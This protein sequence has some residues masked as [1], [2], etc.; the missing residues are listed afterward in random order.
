[1]LSLSSVLIVK[2][3]E[4]YLIL[5]LLYIFSTLVLPVVLKLKSEGRKDSKL[6]P[7]LKRVKFFGRNVNLD[8]KNVVSFM[9]LKITKS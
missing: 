9:T 4:I 1:M 6:A 2:R 7:M 8:A 3:G 5:P